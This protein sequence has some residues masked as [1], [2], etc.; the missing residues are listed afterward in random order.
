[1]SAIAFIA[2]QQPEKR[3]IAQPC[4]PKSRNSCSVEGFSTG[5][6]EAAKMWSLWCGS[7]DDFAPWSSPTIT[8][9]PPCFEVPAALPCLNTSTERSAPG[10][11][12][13][14][15]AKTPS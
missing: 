2:I 11:L 1:M 5:I 8:S 9:T 13:Y 7:E 12:P 15:I 10:P 3:D 14:H 6:M 4:R